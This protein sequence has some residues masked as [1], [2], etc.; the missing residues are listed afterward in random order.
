MTLQ[1]NKKLE[2]QHEELL[3]AS[4]IFSQS[5]LKKKD[6]VYKAIQKHMGHTN[7]HR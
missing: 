2:P 4:S 7:R 1:Q 6:A 3:Q 5:S